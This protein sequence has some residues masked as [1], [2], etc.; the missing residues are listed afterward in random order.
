MNED[1]LMCVVKIKTGDHLRA[2]LVRRTPFVI[3]RS[4]DVDLPVTDLTISRQHLRVEMSEAGL[5]ICDL[6]SNNGTFVEGRKIAPNAP[7]SVAPDQTVIL[8]TS[9]SQFSF[10]VFPALAELLPADELKRVLKEGMLA[11]QIDVEAAKAHVLEEERA[12]VLGLL[13]E[14]EAQLRQKIHRQLEQLKSEAEVKAQGALAAAEK[15]SEQVIQEARKNAESVKYQMLDQV[16]RR[17]EELQSQIEQLEKDASSVAQVIETRAEERA[18]EILKAAEGAADNQLKAASQRSEEVIQEATV[19]ARAKSIAVERQI[20]DWISKAQAECSEIVQDGKSKALIVIE[21]AKK[22]SELILSQARETAS[23]EAERLRR[24]AIDATRAETYAAQEKIIK[25]FKVQIEKLKSEANEVEGK[26]VSTK[27]E[28][29]YLNEKRSK[30]K[31][32]I[33]DIDQYVADKRLA[34]AELST[35][36]EK[37]KQATAVTE[38]AQADLIELEAQSRRAEQHA[39]DVR[40]QLHREKKILS[41]ELEARKQEV[42]LEFA[43]F[44]KQQ[45][46]QA[47]QENL[48][49]MERIKLSIEAEE[50]RY[51]QTLAAKAMELSTEIVAR[52]Q[53]QVA[54][55]V[56]GGPLFEMVHSATEAVLLHQNA[57]IQVVTEHLDIETQRNRRRKIKTWALSI[58]AGLA[59]LCVVFSSSIYSFMK[60]MSQNPLAFEQILR[61]RNAESIYT[62]VQ[63][64]QWRETYTDNVVFLQDYFEAKTDPIYQDQWTLRLTNLE[65]LRSLSLTEDDMVQYIG[66]ER[67]LILKLGDMR[68]NIDAKYSE[69]GLENMRQM[70]RES[71][72]QIKTVLKSEDNWS[73]IKR[74][75]K[76]FMVQY[77]KVRS[78]THLRSPTS[79]ESR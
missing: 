9:Q 28:L 29:E 36:L 48:R 26:L 23:D 33:Q 67:A 54:D 77:M 1:Q 69:I 12:K 8:G 16:Q 62:P 21:E 55:K 11:A 34:L 14:E 50:A 7:L 37:A 18:E 52:L 15:R 65:F 75:E 68:A 64:P 44:R 71:V 45:E 2:H 5:T 31:T 6:N 27:A 76:E 58:G 22:K 10:H 47:A 25:D 3:G 74:I 53:P 38:K 40:S 32:E 46:D 60:D 63:T 17:R 61:R 13:K 24:E 42:V 59:A 35:E 66:K 56:E 19:K 51:R 78:E 39:D 79:Q 57:A 72:A 4:V 30:T 70:E 41:D 20:A 43:A 73:T 49:A